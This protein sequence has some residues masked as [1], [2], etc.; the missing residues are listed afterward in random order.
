MVR[1]D[2]TIRWLADR[3]QFYPAANGDAPRGLGIAVDVTDRKQAEEARR[4]KELELDKT[5]KLAKVGAWQWDPEVDEVIWSEEL[6]R[7]AGLDPMQ[8]A[9]SYK[10]H[11]KLYTAES[12][13]RL[14]RAVEESLRTGTPYELDLEM[15]R[16]DGTT[17]WLIGRGEA[18]RD[19]NGRIVKLHGTVH[20]ITERKQ[21]EFALR[22]S[23]ERFRLVANSAPVMIWMADTDK[24][25]T[26]FNKTWLDFTGHP[27]S[28]ELGNGWIDG[29]HAE[30]RKRCREIYYKAFDRRELF[31]MEYRLLRHDNEYRW[32]SVTGVPRFNSEGSFAG[33]IGSCLDVT[34]Q[35]RAVEA[36]S[37][38]G[39]RMIQAQ[40]QERARIAR[41]LHD[42]I[43]QR[44][45]LTVIELDGIKTE[46][47]GSDPAV[48]DRVNELRNYTSEIA[49]D[50]QTLSHQLHSPRLEHLGL[51]MAMR[52]FC[53]EYG[54][55]YKL[56]IDFQCHDV[57][58]HLP[59]DISLSL[60]RIL[61]E[62]VQ[63][64]AK[65][66]GT[67]RLEVQCWGTPEE[68]QLAVTDAGVGFDFE[69]ATK[70]R[71]LGLFSMHE[72]VRLVGGSISVDSKLLEGT[73]VR[74]RVPLKDLANV[75]S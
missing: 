41:D 50:V 6:Y 14:S 32:I 58:V 30:D 39:S 57:P 18:N 70:G 20:D 31:R 55:K 64:G 24:L 9:P 7:I 47:S 63:N 17:R 22:E 4:E 10:D 45:A 19:D 38:V 52:G 51:V 5:E 12:W 74:V 40:E 61:Q 15:V 53:Q 66:S 2:G 67:S 3:G 71:G 1:P 23:E 59:L 48:F 69:A 11:P 44:L 56:Q 65:H 27:I 42:D 29:V 13:E 62:A 36:L 54:E 26:Y 16:S 25:F 60:F 43:S 21:T 75:S 37:D 28:A 68:I 35:R 46:I 49:A 33:Y 72:R 8:P 34:E 73:V